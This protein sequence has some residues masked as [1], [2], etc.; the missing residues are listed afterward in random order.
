MDHFE[1]IYTL[2]KAWNCVTGKILKHCFKYRGFTDQCLKDM[3]EVKEMETE[4]IN[5]EA[6]KEALYRCFYYALHL[7]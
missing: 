1:G 2:R 7:H 4:K 5:E 6:E 3:L